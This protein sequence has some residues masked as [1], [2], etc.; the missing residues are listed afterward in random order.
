MQFGPLLAQ[1]CKLRLFTEQDLPVFA[2][3]RA[4]VSVARFQSWSSYSLDDAKRLYASLASTVF[5]VPDTWYQIAI[6]ARQDD[7]LLGDCALHF[8]E[9]SQQVE[10]GFTLAP[11]HQGKGLAREAV[12]LLLDYVFAGL[13]KHRVVAI[14]DAENH[15][16][17]RLLLGLGFRQEAYFV[18]NV[19]F[20]G[21]WGDECLFACL[22]SEWQAKP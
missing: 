21:R 3:Y 8:L 13:G 20:K 19:F 4:D 6:A 22:A 1:R 12:T 15:P 14:T 17:K 10:I 9:D 16:A 2:G 11:Q 18:K 7:S 5:G